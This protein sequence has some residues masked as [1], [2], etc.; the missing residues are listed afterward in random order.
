VSD[1][2]RYPSRWLV[3]AWI[4][5]LLLSSSGPIKTPVG[6][7]ATAAESVEVGVETILSQKAR[8]VIVGGYDDFGEEVRTTDLA[9]FS[10]LVFY[11]RSFSLCKLHG[12]ISGTRRS[13]ARSLAR[14]LCRVRTSSR[15]WARRTTRSRTPRRA[16][17]RGRRAAR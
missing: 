8:V 3:A 10:F 6:A 2:E 14:S 15:R 7:C 11:F 1:T 17:C 12:L 4:N 9:S 16:A 5:M 13:L